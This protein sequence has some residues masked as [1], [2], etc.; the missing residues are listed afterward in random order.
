MLLTFLLK[1]WYVSVVFLLIISGGQLLAQ[2]NSL[3]SEINT[4]H[5]TQSKAWAA[6]PGFETQKLY[7]SHPEYGVLPWNAPCSDCYEDL[8]QRTETSRYFVT[9]AHDGIREFNLQQS[10]GAMH[11][12][13]VQGNWISYDK[14]LHKVS[15]SLFRLNDPGFPVEIDLATQSCRIKN[16]SN[17]LEFNHQ[18]ELIAE[19][20]DGRYISLGKANWSDFTAGDQG[21]LVNNCWP[22]ID[23][24][25][26]VY[27][28]AIKT[29][30]IIN[31]P[32]NQSFKS[33]RFRD[34]LSGAG[35]LQN[36]G[37]VYAS[38]EPIA[39]N[40]LEGEMLFSIGVLAVYDQQQLE[41][42][43]EFPYEINENILDMTIPG[44]WLNAPERAY[45]VIIDPLVSANNSV[46]KASI[47]GSKYGTTCWDEYCAY[48]MDV[49]VP[50][51][52]TVTD[53]RFTMAFLATSPCATRDGGMRFTTG[54]CISPSN[55]NWWNCQASFTSFLPGTC[56]GID[57]TFFSDVGSCFKAAQC[58]SYTMPFQL[59]FARCND[60]RPGC[61]GE[62]IGA[63]INW[64]VQIIG[65]TV[66]MSTSQP[67]PMPPTTQTV[68]AGNSAT[69]AVDG[70]FG[71]APYTFSWSPGGQ[72]GASIS[73]SPAS[74]TTFVATATDACGITA[75][76]NFNI[77]VTQG[78]APDFTISPN[79]TCI[80]TPVTILASGAAAASAYDWVLPGAGTASIANMKMFNAQ[81]SS[82]GTYDITLN[83]QSGS[84]TFPLT[85]QVE[86]LA[87][88]SGPSAT[89]S[90]NPPMP[91]C[92]GAGVTYTATPV[93]AGATPTYQWTVNNAPVGT[94]SATFTSSTLVAGDQVRVTVT[95]SLPCITPNTGTSPPLTVSIAPPT[96]PSVSINVSPATP[97]CPG[98][99][100][101]YTATPSNAGTAPTYQWLVNN[102]PA[103]SG[104]PTF[105]SSTLANGDRVSV[106]LTSNSP[107]SS[108][109]NASSPELTVN[110]LPEKPPAVTIAANPA[111]AVCQGVQI[112]FTATAT[113]GG[114]TPL[115]T[116]KVNGVQ[117]SGANNSSFASSTLNNNDVVTV[118]LS[119]SETCPGP[120]P[121]V[122]SNPI[123]V[124][125]TPKAVPTVSVNVNPGIDIC[126]GTAVTFTAIPFN[127]GVVPGYQWFINNT[128]VSG[129]TA[130]GFTS[131][132]LSHGDQ[133]FVRMQ[134]NA[135]CPDPASVESA[136]VVMQVTPTL[137][138]SV[139]IAT[140][141]QLPIC[142]G[143]PIDL[144]ASYNN[145]G[146][147]P[148]ISWTVNGVD[149]GN[150]TT[151]LNLPL[152]VN[153]DFVQVKIVPDG[154]CF[155]ANE[156]VSNTISI[157]VL[158]N[159]APSVSITVTPSDT[160]CKNSYNM[161]FIATPVN[162]G[163]NPS[164]AWR[165][166]GTNDGPD[167]PTYTNPWIKVDDVVEVELSSDYQC[168]TT[169]NA[170]S[171]AITVKGYSPI[172]PDAGIDMEICQDQTITL[173]ASATGGKAGMK[174]YTWTPGNITGNPIT[175]MPATTTLYMVEVTDRC[176]SFLAYDSVQVV[177][178][179]NPNAHFTWNPIEPILMLTPDVT[180][181][182]PNVIP[183]TRQW[184]FG[185]GTSST[186]DSP[187]HA[188]EKKGTYT[189]Q[190]YATSDKGCKSTHAALL[191]IKDV[192]IFYIPNSFT[193][194]GDGINDKFEFFF[195]DSI[196]FSFQVFNRWG[197][198]VFN[199]TEL[200]DF[201]DG[202]DAS[203]GKLVPDGIYLYKLMYR[204]KGFDG[205]R[206]LVT[207][208]G[209][210]TLLKRTKS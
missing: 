148:A 11:Y 2:N 180:F 202:T 175:V 97:V 136:P 7:S 108:T 42:G 29:N 145:V 94:N 134:S 172:I 33:L 84:C 60:P 43:L 124:T 154:R 19:T 141:Q 131:T 83:Y 111:G 105:T 86:I 106:K 100:L 87:P 198:M 35:K 164:Y 171:N 13:D 50:P 204:Q 8:S 168:K 170:L 69:L 109:P 32:L 70:A 161:Q 186:E 142:E 92:T 140:S 75:T 178:N 77:V 21:V 179:P 4:F 26:V 120:N 91:I 72:T 163:N 34:K 54:S 114:P 117:V 193:P 63:D 194:N 143:T 31:R 177:V 118:E 20:A 89:I 65:R 133:V 160:V 188:F 122:T 123:S 151:N 199:G 47:L 53:A 55:G 45:P 14:R 200:N 81:Y 135:T 191:N 30:F 99:A 9:R 10:Y 189:V 176:G 44:A 112:A 15:P 74:N 158:P 51:N 46:L 155:T 156:Y 203:S 104:G 79:P 113:N 90:S 27:K 18:L 126:S 76:K 110:L 37:T 162:G 62:C 137:P 61:S 183:V 24:Q 17:M 56:S 67:I 144:T 71:V 121:L 48:D 39:I 206:P 159:L 192:N 3:Q 208:H 96:T 115:F 201:W 41:S 147:N 166:N 93:D 12:K 68:C 139:S 5:F 149:A 23:M 58:A 167:N 207:L 119:S 182:N 64:T 59:R 16:G 78:P 98:T 152:P 80:N 128:A 187:A 38:T 103:G 116:W 102:V 95:A 28:G 130:A 22:G 88:G 132:T 153:G 209:H 66:E 107:C 101:T 36:Q 138:G 174:S 73:V 197:E 129:A 57:Y 173:Q 1:R 196:P 169:A 52:C 195:N 6:I 181:N 85:K 205:E 125:I 190:L 40:S 184:D 165:L 25:M 49:P 157:Q 185:D 127:G 82:A 150:S 210:I 146:T